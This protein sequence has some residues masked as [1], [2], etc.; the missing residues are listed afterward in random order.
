MSSYTYAEHLEE[1]AKPHAGFIAAKPEDY[2]RPHPRILLLRRAPDKWSAGLWE[3]PGS[4]YKETDA[5]VLACA[6]RKVFEET[7]CRVSRFVDLVALDKWQL[8][9]PQ[10]VR[11]MEKYMFLV[12]VDGEDWEK[13]IKL[14]PNQHDDFL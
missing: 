14:A 3:T 4:T 12:E 2:S 6:S 11:Y 1:H 9:R 7:G 8:L 10:G 13:K 5:S